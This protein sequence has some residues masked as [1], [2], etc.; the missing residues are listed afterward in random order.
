MDIS[1]N[2]RSLVSRAFFLEW[3][4][5]GWMVVEAAV[6][7][8]AGIAAHSI[9]LV[10]FGA[11]SLIELVSA[12]VLIWRLTVELRQGSAFSETVEERAGKISGG[13][14]FALSA[15]VV[16]SAGWSLWQREGAEFSIP[17][18][19]LACVAIPVMYGLSRA[20]TRLATALGSRSLR[21]DAVEAIACGYLSVVV[22]VGLLAQL[23]FRAWWMDGITSLAIVYFLVKEARE[24]WRGEDCCGD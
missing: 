18:V 11:D 10:A 16:V 3:L 8:F 9:T 1:E 22:V 24:A 5:V 19:I 17:G 20:K 4:T 12:L 2:R 21:A 15:Y 14:L 6:A 7:L 13:L 23:I